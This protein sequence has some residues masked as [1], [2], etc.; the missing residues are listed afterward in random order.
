MKHLETPETA[1]TL[2]HLK[3]YYGK[4]ACKAHQKKGIIETSIPTLCVQGGRSFLEWF[5]DMVESRPLISTEVWALRK[6]FEIP[7]TV[8]DHSIR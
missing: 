7:V 5:L 2:K 6:F 3:R 8:P 4:S 1:E